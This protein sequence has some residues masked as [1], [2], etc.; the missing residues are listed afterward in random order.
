MSLKIKTI[1]NE[2]VKIFSSLN[3]NFIFNLKTGVFM[4]WGKTHD[5]NPEYSK[6]GPEILDI[7][8]SSVCS[9]NCSFCYKTNTHIGENMDVNT[10]KKMFGKF[11]KTLTQ[12]AF[13]IGDI[14]ANKDLYKILTHC[15]K[16][17]VIPNITINGSRMT[18]VHY[19]KLTKLCGAVAVSLYN[20][21]VCYNAVQQLTNRGMKQ[22]NI[23][24]L[25]S[26]ETFSTCMQVLK[27]KQNDKRLEKLNAIVFLWLKPKGLRNKFTQLKDMDK[28]KQLVT[29]AFDNNISIGFD[30]CSASNF[31]KSIEG[32][33]RYK[34][35]EQM[36]EA[37]ESTLFSYYI[38]VEG[39]GFPCS[40]SENINGYTGVNVVNC[41]DF[42]KDVWNANQ[43][44][45]FREM[46]LKTKDCNNCRMC[47]IYD[48]EIK[49]LHDYQEKAIK[50]FTKKKICTIKNRKYLEVKNEMFAL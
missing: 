47:S 13:G 30:S 45:R 27:D 20:A 42:I 35:I 2:K 3:Y 10:F 26:E 43:T 14:D 36:I 21:N 9:N 34:Q 37:C 48:L 28:F 17:E 23:H 1:N 8:I 12:I 22:V 18:D 19:D 6:F 25:L 31:L 46:A 33:K 24:C 41:T 50:D 38:N 15:R 11:T 4:R 32:N 39:I 5:E 16:N 44:R 40:F 7:E 49:K 29:Y